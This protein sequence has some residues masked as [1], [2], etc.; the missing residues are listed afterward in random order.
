MI[1]SVYDTMKTSQRFVSNSFMT[2]PM[3]LLIEGLGFDID[4][5]IGYHFEVDKSKN[6][7]PLY[8]PAAPPFPKATAT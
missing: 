4:I 1:L 8:G 7:I 3:A 5:G 6:S 2:N